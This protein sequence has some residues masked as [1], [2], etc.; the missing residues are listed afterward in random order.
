MAKLTE[1]KQAEMFVV[2]CEKPSVRYV[3]QKCQVSRTTA[4]RYKAKDNWDKRLS[5]IKLKAEKKTDSQL[6]KRLAENLK[7]VRFAK[8]ELVKKIQ[9]GK[10]KSTSTYSEL[11]KLIRLEEFLLGKPDSRPDAGKFDHLSDEELE[12]KLKNLQKL[13]KTLQG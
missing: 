5:E 3:S 4:G 6:A 9:K 8:A 13:Q 1:Q 12:E 2:Y 10:D 11:D 7:I